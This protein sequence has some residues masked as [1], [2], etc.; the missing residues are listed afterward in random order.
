MSGTIDITLIVLSVHASMLNTI[1]QDNS[2]ASFD[3]K[4]DFEETTFFTFYE[5][6]GQTLPILDL[7]SKHGIA[8]TQMWTDDCGYSGVII[9]RFTSLGES[10]NK[11]LNDSENNPD[12]EQCLNLIDK[13][14]ELREYILEH[15]AS[16]LFLPWDN[17][18]QNG[19][20]Y[21]ARQ[22]INA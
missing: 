14:I 18:E 7:L 12:S 1:M 22:L 6:R 20:L 10:I 13:P 16:R 3:E 2:L 4:Y 17:Q 19:K 15:Q 9:Q 21:M 5:C 8:F 11:N